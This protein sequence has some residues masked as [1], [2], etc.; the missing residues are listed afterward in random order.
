MNLCTLGNVL[1]SACVFILLWDSLTCSPDLLHTILPSTG[2]ISVHFHVWL[3]TIDLFSSF[4]TPGS[5]VVWQKWPLTSTIPPNNENPYAVPTQIAF[6]SF[7]SNSRLSHLKVNGGLCPNKVYY[8]SQVKLWPDPHIG[9]I[10]ASPESGLLR[11][12]GQS[13]PQVHC[14][15]LW[16][17][18]TSFEEHQVIWEFLSFFFFCT[19]YHCP[20]GIEPRPPK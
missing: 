9:L 17:E 11:G 6:I 16:S 12:R 14:R 5:Y 2:I 3:W 15:S 18:A 4:S 8:H 1:G 10:S 13:A 20:P 19:V 7:S